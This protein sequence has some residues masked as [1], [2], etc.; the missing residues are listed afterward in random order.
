[1]DFGE[2]I[3]HNL[4]DTSA[5]TSAI[6]EADLRKIQLLAPQRVLN[7]R[8]LPDFQILLANGHSET[9]S[10]TAELQ[11]EVGDILVKK[12]FIIITKLTSPL[13]GLLF[14]QRNSTILGM[15]QGLLNFFSFPM[16]LTHADNTY[17]NLNDTFSFNRGNKQ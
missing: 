12:R 15:P 14:L 3:I 13:F 7:E 17:S 6:S 9:P 2:S 11:L 8:P 5:S 4:T 1:M 16:Q 10:D